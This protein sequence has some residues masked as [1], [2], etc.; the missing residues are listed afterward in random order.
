MFHKNKGF[1]LIELLV[2]IAIIG[3]LAS[4]V[5]VNLN[6]ARN[7]AKA[8]AIKAA[9]SETRIAAEMHYDDQ[10]PNSYS[11]FCATDPDYARIAVNIAANGG[12]IICDDSAG[13]G[14]CVQSSL[15]TGGDWCVD[16]RGLS[17]STAVSCVA[18]AGN[19]CGGTAF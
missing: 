18:A 9:L 1:T 3:I 12:T 14:Y 7:K 2:V 15:P 11:T 5:L 19:D 8:A 6:A 17:G 13:T 10:T 4:I 16:S